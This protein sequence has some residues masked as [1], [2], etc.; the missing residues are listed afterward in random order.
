MELFDK[1]K[2]ETSKDL[3][4]FL[5]ENKEQL[6]TQK[7]AV[8]KHGDGIGAAGIRVMKTAN[9]AEP[10]GQDDS[11]QVLAVINTT[12]V[13]DSHDDVHIPGLW[14]KTLKENRR[15]MHIQEHKAEFDKIIASREDL[16]A[17]ANEYTFKE[18][19]FD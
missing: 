15:I 14:D 3:H 16:K 9:K 6:I 1:S 17:Y 13:L 7:R 2:F 5:V 4:K 10:T 18:L 19:G 12:N 8:M 11:V